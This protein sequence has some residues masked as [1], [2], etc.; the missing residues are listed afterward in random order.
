MA[1]PSLSPHV[2]SITL[3]N[4]CI[5]SCVVNEDLQR[6]RCELDEGGRRVN[7]ALAK[8]IYDGPRLHSNQSPRKHCAESLW[9]FLAS[10]NL[11]STTR[12]I[13]PI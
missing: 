11:N 9:L 7:I 2:P 6:R 10:I 5:V 1:K 12:T 8:E 4:G 3:V 13:V